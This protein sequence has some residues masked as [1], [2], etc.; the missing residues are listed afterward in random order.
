MVVLCESND[1]EKTEAWRTFATIFEKDGKRIAPLSIS[2]YDSQE[3]EGEIF[4][5]EE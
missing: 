3:E 5:V 2:D 1:A 4:D